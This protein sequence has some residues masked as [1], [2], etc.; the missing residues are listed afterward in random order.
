MLQIRTD[1]AVEAREMYRENTQENTEIHGVQAET[2]Q[3]DGISITRVRILNDHGEQVLGKPKGDYITLEMPRILQRETWL[4]RKVTLH[5]AEELRRQIPSSAKQIL[6]VGLGNR[7]ITP[8]ALGPQTVE[9]VFVTRHLKTYMPQQFGSGVRGVSAI[10]PGVLGLTGIE[11]NEMIRSVVCHVKPDCIIAVDALAARRTDRVNTT[12]Q[13]SD[14]GIRPGAGVGNHRGALTED[15]LGVPVIALGV[16]T[17]VDAATIT[18][19]ALDLLLEEIQKETGK[20]AETFRMFAGIQDK[21]ELIYEILSPREKNLMV[22]PKNVDVM[23]EEM[24]KILAGGINLALHQEI[25][26]EEAIRC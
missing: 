13:I 18:S 1:L 26:Y 2:T 24:A 3:H 14:T 20:D 7:N 16:P 5:L 8:D 15:F 17:V 11:T 4:E 6:V 21:Y 12:I 9:R 10:S 25:S 19:D 22:T 23:T